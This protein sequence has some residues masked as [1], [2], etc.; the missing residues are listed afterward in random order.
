MHPQVRDPAVVVDQFELVHGRAPNGHVH[1][2]PTP[3]ELVRALAADLDRRRGRD[4]QVDLA[5][6][7]G[8]ALLELLLR[9][10]VVLLDDLALGIPGGRRGREVHSRLVLLRQPH[11]LLRLLGESA[12]QDEQQARGEGVERAGVARPRAGSVAQVADD[13]E[14]RGAGRLVDEHRPLGVRPRLGGIRRGGELP[15][16]R[17]RDLLDRAL[18]WRSR[19]PGG[20]RRRR[21]SGARSRRRRARPSRLAG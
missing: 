18:R 21:P 14:R 19:P 9:R 3:H 6:E 10:W 5:A 2:H 4:L 17:L 1:L 11:E 13:R 15:P 20:G 7:R 12:E 8:D 16:D